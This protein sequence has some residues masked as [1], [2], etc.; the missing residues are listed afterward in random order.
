MT[1]ANIGDLMKASPSGDVV[2]DEADVPVGAT[3]VDEGPLFVMD[4]V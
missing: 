2:D 1:L 4:V 3:E